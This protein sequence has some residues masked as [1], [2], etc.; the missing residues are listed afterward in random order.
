MNRRDFIK[1]F[2]LSIG[3]GAV[4]A[5]KTNGE[6]KAEAIK[7]QIK[8]I[9]GLPLDF[10]FRIDEE[11]V[12]HIIENKTG[13]EIGGIQDLHWNIHACELISCDMRIQFNVTPK[14]ILPL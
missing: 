8:M 1:S 5:T 13:E 12:F 6:T 9:G 7:K 2:L 10:H 3:A 11:G 4:L 14:D